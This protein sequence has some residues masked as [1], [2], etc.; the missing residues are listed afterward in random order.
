MRLRAE[1]D[2]TDEHAVVRSQKT[3]GHEADGDLVEVVRAHSG[4]TA[5]FYAEALGVST[6]KV[7][8]M[9]QRL[10]EAGSLRREGRVYVWV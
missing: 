2:V 9:A 7:G 10:I 3:A 6:Q 5:K 8:K 4:Q 1:A